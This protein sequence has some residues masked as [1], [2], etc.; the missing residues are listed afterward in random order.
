MIVISAAVLQT[1]DLAGKRG[2]RKFG[3][4]EGLPIAVCALSGEVA[5]RMCSSDVRMEY[6]IH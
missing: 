4:S 5:V 3:Y 2:L 6:S 1:G